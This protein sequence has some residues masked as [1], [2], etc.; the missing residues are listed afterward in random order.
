MANGDVVVVVINWKSKAVKNVKF[1]FAEVGISDAVMDVKDLWQ[2]G[3]ILDQARYS[4]TV[5]SLPSHG[6]AALRFSKNTSLSTLL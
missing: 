5:A 2:D 4:Y 3:L 6:N 1:T